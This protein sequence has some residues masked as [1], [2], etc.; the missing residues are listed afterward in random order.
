MEQLRDELAKPW[1]TWT[2]SI[3]WTLISLVASPGSYL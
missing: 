3:G 2:T 1:T